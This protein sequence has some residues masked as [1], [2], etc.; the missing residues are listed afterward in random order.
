MTTHPLVAAYAAEV[1]RAIARIEQEELE[2]ARVCDR[3]TWAQRYRAIDGQPFTLDRHK[4]LRAIYQDDHPH[5][6]VMKC[7]Q[8][9]VS[10]L[11]ITAALHALDMGARYY[12][13]GLDGLNVAY[14]FPT[15]EALRDFSKERVSGVTSES[16]YLAGLFRGGWDDVGF[17]QV[18]RSYLYLRGAWTRGDGKSPGLKSFKADL[19]IRDEYDEMSP[20]AIAMSEKRVRASTVRRILDISTPTLTGHGI[21]AAYLASDK[22]VWEV[23]C[24]C[25]AWTTL[26]FFRDVYGNGQPHAVWQHWDRTLITRAQWS[27]RCPA[28]KQPLD[29]LADGRWVATQPDVTDVHGYHIPALCF[30]TIDLGALALAAI[31]TDPTAIEE[32][33][34]SD[35]GLPF[36]RTGTKVEPSMLDAAIV[37]PLPAGPWTRTTMGVDVGARFHVRISSEAP[38]RR[39][40][41]RYSGAVESFDDLNT[42]IGQYQVRMVVIDAMPELNATKQWAARW[43]GRVWRALYNLSDADGGLVVTKDDERIARINRTMAMDRLYA[44]VAS[45]ELGWAKAAAHDPETRAHLSAPQR[46]TVKGRDGQPLTSWVHTA[47]DHLYHAG[48]Y[49]TIA[50]E[51][52][53]AIKI[54][55]LAGRS[56]KVKLNQ[57]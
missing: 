36:S 11:A 15:A 49:D 33:W 21:H 9:G 46:V 27:V 3:L 45:G 39:R 19:L 41:V 47:P 2:A 26:D 53:P 48:V 25:G 51:L 7:A 24:R 52:L 32:F 30:P 34:R 38:D 55:G 13:T 50:R 31:A 8:V 44:E 18:G 57:R 42:L 17:K 35:L 22:R 37:H 29:R 20:L 16:D 4:P 23:P 14:L 6:V 5:V 40:Y 56:A 28:C 43:P 54:G 12:A 1:D 10:E